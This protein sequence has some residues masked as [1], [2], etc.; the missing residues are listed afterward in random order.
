MT[1]VDRWLLPDGIEEVLPAQAAAVE[2]LRRR[3]LDL[4]R[5]W[6]YQLIIP[7]LVEF[8]E[9]L[10]I[11]LGPD[12]DL[13]TFKL[14]DQISG[15]TLGIRADIT[16]QVARIDAHSLP[17]EGVS[18]FCYAGS[19]LHTRPK[20]Q[21]ASR[22][23]IQVGVELFGDASLDADLEVIQLM[24][25][26]LECA[27]LSGFTLDLG[28]VGIVEAVFNAA[29]LSE[30]REAAIFDA[31]QRKSIPDLTAAS[32]DL[33][34]VEANAI[35]ALARLHG[36][37]S[38]L[39]QAR[40]DLGALAPAAL[41]ALDTLEQVA[42]DVRALRPELTIYFD[43]AEL[44][45]YHY[46]TGVVFA[47]YVPGHG[48]ALANGGR[49]DDVGEVFGRARPATGFATDLKSLMGLLHSSPETTGAVAMPA[50]RDPALAQAVQAL[51]DAGE[52]VIADLG[53]SPDPRCT[54]R[55]LLEAGEW[56]VKPLSDS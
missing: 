19:T 3:L 38:V 7:P 42:R 48:Q 43:L 20:T 49:Y 41:P 11:G 40:V 4:Y 9:S 32:A 27:G 23:P 52:I 18:R 12:I 14:T 22:S 50:D 17:V 28:H 16:P 46:H 26:T 37:E 54:R 56:V 29:G 6:G 33:P 47:A 30:E 1:S 53:Q 55:L 51:R 31:L 15:R 39:A 10:I 8:T 44:R 34:D 25:Q 5:G 21:L 24:L 45:G 36:D 35:Q 13:Q 2:V